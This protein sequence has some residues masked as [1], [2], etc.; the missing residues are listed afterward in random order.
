MAQ[1][2][3][4]VGSVALQG[5]QAKVW[6]SENLDAADFILPKILMAQATSQAAQDGLVVPGALYKSTTVESLTDK[7]NT[8]VG[9]LVVDT[10]KSWR[11]SEI[12]GN[13]PKFVGREPM[14]SKNADAVL[15]WTDGKNKFRRDRELNYYVLLVD[16]VAR[17]AK[18]MKELAA[19]GLPDTEDALLPCVLSFTRT[20]FQAG[21]VLATHMAK[22]AHFNRPAASWVFTVGT[23]KVENDQG[24]F[25]VLDVGLKSSRASTPEEV[26]AAKKWHT[27]LAKATVKIDDSDEAVEPI[28]PKG[29]VAADDSFEDEVNKTF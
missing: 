17:E 15:E 22:A 26:E 11:I 7:K 13:R 6:G 27:T 20:S 21:K 29:A 4:T 5:A 23:K 3:S 28:A 8:S 24:T 1:E 18:A 10:W 2:I 25:F 19:G 12:S 16:D 14:T 9:V